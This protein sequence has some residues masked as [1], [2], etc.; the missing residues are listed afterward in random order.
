M[1]IWCVR[2]WTSRR[3]A[4]CRSRQTALRH[5]GHA[6][7]ARVYA[8]DPSRDF[9]PQ[10]G[11]A[12]RVRWPHGPFV[13]V[14]RGLEAGDRVGV[15]YDPLLAKI[16]AYGDTRAAALQRL[17]AALDAT[18]IH[19]VVTN[20]P[21]LRALARDVRVADAAFDTEWIEREFL[22][23]FRALAEAPA[24]ELALAALAIAEQ[25]GMHAAGAR[26]GREPGA[27]RAPDPFA[28]LGP[29]RLPGLDA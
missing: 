16:V 29:W 1:S 22:G 9:L 17:A 8:E 23:D 13:R 24:P 12:V 25:L 6:I 21:F 3:R 27:S 2:N 5:R 19:G 11:L 4:A 7:E 26:R 28:T 20:L 10:A 15:H 14:D 18:R